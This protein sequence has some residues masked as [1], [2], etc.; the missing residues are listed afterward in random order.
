MTTRKSRES[1]AEDS[2]RIGSDQHLSTASKM[3]TID[4]FTERMCRH[5]ARPHSREGGGAGVWGGGGGGVKEVSQ[6]GNGAKAG[7]G[8]GRARMKCDDESGGYTMLPSVS[9]RGIDNNDAHTNEVL[10][11][12]AASRGELDAQPPP[13]VAASGQKSEEYSDSNAGIEEL[14]TWLHRDCTRRECLNRG[15]EDTGAS[16]SHCL[17]N[18]VPNFPTRFWKVLWKVRLG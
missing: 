18:T 2:Y 6:F 11:V 13:T 5:D 7:G 12:W 8:E 10:R 14:D 9:P 15:S 1:S 4:G 16:I 3:A 17:G